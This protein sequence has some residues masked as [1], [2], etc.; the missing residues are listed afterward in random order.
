MGKKSYKKYLFDKNSPIPKTTA[1]RLK[2]KLKNSA[3][4]QSLRL[5]Q[6]TEVNSTQNFFNV[7][8]DNYE[9]IDEISD[10]NFNEF[11]MI[12][13]DTTREKNSTIKIFNS[14]NRP[15]DKLSKMDLAIAILSV[16][17]NSNLTQKALEN[18]LNLMNFAT[19]YDLPNNFNQLSKYI[20]EKMN[21][22][23]KYKKIWFCDLCIKTFDSLDEELMQCSNES[24]K[25]K[26]RKCPHCSSRLSMYFHFMIKQ[27]LN[28]IFQ[29]INLTD[30]EISN[31]RILRDISD[32]RIHKKISKEEKTTNSNIFTL[33]ISTDGV[34][35]CEK[36]NLGIW[37]VYCVC[38]EIKKELRFCPENVIILGKYRNKANLN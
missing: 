7:D 9:N 5:L 1:W 36:S 8:C 26:N 35:L 32:G 28:R 17:F 34:S 38:Y 29:E 27:Q 31:P 12:D 15:N 16:F 2:S 10:I 30:N 37:P 33:T 4:A 22:E 19:S 25:K 23:I 21:D 20:M 11:R 14:L 13:N 24:K 18:V 3:S 6:K